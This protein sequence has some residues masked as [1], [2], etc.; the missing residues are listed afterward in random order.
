MKTPSIKQTEVSHLGVQCKAKAA[1]IWDEWQE[2]ISPFFDLSLREE[3]D[4]SKAISMRSYHLGGVLVGEIEAPAQDLVREARKAARQ[5]VDHVLMQFY[6]R[7]RSVVDGRQSH[8]ADAGKA[9]V[10]DLSQPVTLRSDKAVN[11][12]NILLPR[13]LLERENIRVE[14]LHGM[15]ID[16]QA[17][18]A[19]TIALTTLRSVLDCVDRLDTHHLPAFSD[20]TARLCTSFLHGASASGEPAAFRARVGLRSFV[21]DNLHDPDLGADLLQRRFGMSRAALYREFAEEG[22]VQTYI[23][24]RRLA[25][26][27]RR[28][29]RPSA[30]GRRPRVSSVAYSVGFEDEKTFSRAF[31]AR[32]GFLPSEVRTG[33]ALLS[34][35][36]DGADVLL[37]WMRDLT[38]EWGQS[39]W[40]AG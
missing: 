13:A 16:H 3:T 1:G 25:A 12:V 11:A 8:V 33:E 15:V 34:D 10:Y 7:G 28:L 21:R 17:D 36:E 22:G 24:E 27:L 38:G 20:A 19:G 40:M 37:S 14:A 35:G 39:S 29:T 6:T 9:I 32:F 18:A 5:G 26:A 30:Q 23:R 2:H 4:L 31:K